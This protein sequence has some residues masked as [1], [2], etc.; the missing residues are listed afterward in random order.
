MTTE[1][2]PPVL[3]IDLA[4]LIHRQWHCGRSRH[5]SGATTH[6]SLL[7]MADLLKKFRPSRVIVTEEGGHEYRRSIYP[8]YKSS[9]PVKETGLG[10]E[11]CL[12]ASACRTLGIPVMSADGY[13]ADDVIGEVTRRLSKQQIPVVVYS[14]D[15]DLR[16]L[17]AYPSVCVVDGR[18]DGGIIAASDVVER[19]GVTAEQLGD[20]LALMGDSVD[21]VPGV[22]GV[23]EVAAARLL[24]EHKT[25]DGVLQWAAVEAEKPK[26]KKFVISLRDNAEMARLSRRLVELC[27]CEPRCL[28]WGN[29]NATTTFPV[30]GW[31]PRLKRLGLK[32]CISGLH[33]AFAAMDKE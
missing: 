32:D 16:Q 29:L 26:A 19:F 30:D 27:E 6:W 14:S 20:Y 13:E 10:Y 31:K 12:F 2:S 22:P 24:R 21:D 7:N 9:R 4:N 23:G 15:K 11:L 8:E 25:L 18:R 17:L 1:S 28:V 3:L 33:D 5:T